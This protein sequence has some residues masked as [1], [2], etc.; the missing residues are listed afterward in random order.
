MHILAH[1]KTIYAPLLVRPSCALRL[2][3][4][5]GI[6][7]VAAG[8]WLCRIQICCCQICRTLAHT[9]TT[10]RPHTRATYMVPDATSTRG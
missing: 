8:E 6:V 10:R 4:A 1:Q 5:R 7:A 9:L 2:P 3:A